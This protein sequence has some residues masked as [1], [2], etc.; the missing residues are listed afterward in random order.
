MIACFNKKYGTIV[1]IMYDHILS[2]VD[3]SL[4]RGAIATKLRQAPR[5]GHA[6]GGVLGQVFARSALGSGV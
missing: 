6:V 5:G 2:Q 3:E 4:K 1:S